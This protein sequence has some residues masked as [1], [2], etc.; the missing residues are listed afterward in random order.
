METDFSNILE[1]EESNDIGIQLSNWCVSSFLSNGIISA[2]FNFKLIWK[3]DS[4]QRLI[5]SRGNW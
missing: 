1:M 5:Q 4:W 2:I 3:T